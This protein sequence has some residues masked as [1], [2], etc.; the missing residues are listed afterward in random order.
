MRA[1]KLNSDQRLLVRRAAD[2]E[3]SERFG[4]AAEADEAR[5]AGGIGTAH[6]V[7]AN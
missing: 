5:A 7:V 6:R 2:L 4:P 1:S 3:R